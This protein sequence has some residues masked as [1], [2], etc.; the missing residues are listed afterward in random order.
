M[1]K[2]TL[3]QIA[4]LLA[5]AAIAAPLAKALRIG[6]VLGYIFA[7]I[8][9]GP[10]GLGRLAGL[11]IGDKYSVEEVLHV[12]E[13]GVVLLLF[14]IGLE[15]RV[16]RLWTMR[17][18]IF[19]AGG[20]QVAISGVVIGLA[21]FLLGMGAWAA[22]FMGLALSLSST[23]FALQVMEEN[24]EL[25]QRHGRL[26]F[27]ILLFQDLAAIPLIALASL[28]AANAGTGP[29]QELGI[30]PILIALAAIAGV[31]LAGRF[32]VD[33]FF[34]FVAGSRMNDALTAAALLVVVVVVLVM[35][36]AGL[37]ASLGAFLAGV[38][39][40]DSAYRH[41]IEADIRPFEGLLLGVFFT[42]IGMSLDVLLLVRSPLLVLG[43]TAGLLVVKSLV[44]Y[45]VGRQFGLS[46]RP[47]RR[48]AF[49]I[50]QGGE[51]AFVLLSAG[52]A[53]SLL[54]QDHAALAA[55]VV[56][57]SMM[58]TP[59]LLIAEQ[60]LWRRPES[61]S[62][63]FDDMP[64]NDGHVIVAGYG[65]VGQILSRVL[66]ARKIPFTA[67]DVDAK[68]IA[69]VKRFGA[70]AYFGDASRPDIL[71]AAQAGKA[72][73]FVLAID[74]VEA[75]LRTARAVRE[76]YPALP[77]YARARNRRHVHELMDL[78]IKIIHRET[79]G[80]SLDLTR[81]LL[82]GLGVPKER[83]L[84]TLEIFRE[85]DEKRLKLDY[86]HFTDEEKLRERA[87]AASEELEKLLDQDAAAQA[88]AEGTASPLKPTLETT[89]ASQS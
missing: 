39:L 8:L 3:G 76:H 1:D 35:Q 32:L 4:L 18:S 38:V 79:F 24:N 85:T 33:P 26:G 48:L 59:A 68:Q 58:A 65:R 52:V 83:A 16:Q 56:T 19:G 86:A 73:A 41:E 63:S 70:K 80:S 29:A 82:V 31:L 61:V 51:F 53:S 27:A 77:I 60:T 11:G 49:S 44:I 17:A 12:A 64:E 21:V 2:L 88:V 54:Q 25:T 84:S 47:A 45:G 40:A 7:G 66:R 69:T 30:T 57:L 42:A 34:R 22:L 20:L 71:E 23:A 67:L 62:S 81:D 5:A 43:L 14:L 75:S 46:G 6:T 13:F 36:K 74:D 89:R 55:V 87:L 10:Y 28:F 78:G 37:S 72:R 9:I 15:L 50:S